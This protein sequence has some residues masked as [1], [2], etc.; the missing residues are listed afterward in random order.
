[1]LDDHWV[2]D[3]GVGAPLMLR[4]AWMKFGEPFDV[5]LVDD[6]VTPRDVME[7][8][9]SPVELAVDHNGSRHEVGRIRSIECQVV[10][11]DMP[12]DRG[13]QSQLAL[14]RPGIRVDQ[15]LVR[16]PPMPDVGIPGSVDPEA[17]AGSHRHVVHMPVEDVEHPVGD[18][19]A[20]LGTGF[21]EQAQLDALGSFS[22]HGDVDPAMSVGRDA[23]WVPTRTRMCTRHWIHATRAAGGKA[24]R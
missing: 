14:D 8:V 10:G 1:M 2:C 5:R 20:A 15:Q 13:I 21:I 18:V 23:K 22:P 12:E 19:D 6:G 11:A 16:I 24:R 9:C 3:T 4:H 17:V 7:L